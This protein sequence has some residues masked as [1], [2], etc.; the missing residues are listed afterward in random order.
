MKTL[1]MLEMVRGLEAMTPSL[2]AQA[3]EVMSFIGK[4]NGLALDA[5]NCSTDTARRVLLSEVSFNMVTVAESCKALME[6]C[7]SIGE[8]AAK[9][10]GAIG[11][12]K[13]VEAHEE[14]PRDRKRSE[15]GEDPRSGQDGSFKFAATVGNVVAIVFSDDDDGQGDAED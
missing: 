11:V 7:R 2:K 1:D 15:S 5:K 8:T 10:D 9:I 4:A 12:R 13:N 3:G 14:P 6:T